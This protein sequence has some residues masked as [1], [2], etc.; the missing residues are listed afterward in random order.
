MTDWLRQA[1]GA[2]FDE[3]AFRF[4]S[5]E[6][7]DLRLH[8]H[9]L[10][11]RTA[12]GGPVLVLHGTTGSGT[13][14]LQPAMADALFGE[15]RPLDAERHFIILPDAIGHGM[16]SKPSDGLR[17]SFPRYGYGDIV[18]AQHLLVTRHLGVSHLRLVLGTSMGGMQTWMWGQSYP[19]LMDA[20][21]P[22][23]SLPER[24]TGRNLLWRRL[25]LEIIRTDHNYRDGKTAMGLGLAWNV[26]KLLVDSPARMAEHLP[27]AAAAD[28]LVRKTAADAIAAE[29]PDD[30]IR[31]FEASHDYDPGPGLGLITAPLLAVN[32]QD[33]D[34]N[35]AALGVLGD[36]IR[37]VPNGRAVTLPAGPRSH[38]HQTLSTP[39]LWSDLVRDL[40]GSAP[41]RQGNHNGATR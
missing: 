27:D 9:T 15:G 11:S 16:S 41:F 5:G 33:D 10:G 12:E 32:F 35:P 14:F 39:E 4:G 6:R 13:Q 19:E 8:C 37:K 23:A 40:L 2:T 36:A 7:L 26:F 29:D 22:V 25:M 21:M 30:V 24:V 31:E 17:Q 38:G 28:A 3:P 20:L 18:R 1:A 34:V